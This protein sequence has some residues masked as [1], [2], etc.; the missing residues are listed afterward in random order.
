M[1]KRSLQAAGLGAALIIAGALL[2]GVRPQRVSATADAVGL[3]STA[4]HNLQESRDTA[5]PALLDRAERL[6]RKSLRLQHARNFEAFLGMASLSNA[7]HRFTDSVKWAKKAI[8]VN[9]YNASSY[10]LLGDALFELGHYRQADRAYQK[11][12]DVRPDL[13]S[14]V[15]ASY[16]FQ[17]HGDTAAAIGALRLA[18]EAAGSDRIQAAW[19]RHQLGDVYFGM[20]DLHGAARQ[21]RIGIALAPGYVPPHVGLAEVAIGRGRLDRAIPV[22]EDATRRLPTLEYL[23]TLG[24]LYSADGR[25]DEAWSAY[26]RARNKIESYYEHGVEP[27]VDFVLFYAEH[28]IELER[29]LRRAHAIYA[30]RPTGSA[31]DAV[32]W[33]LH[34]LGRDAEA[35]PYIR[36]AVRTPLVDASV[37]LHAGVI[38]QELG[39]DGYAGR[40]LR[41]ASKQALQ[42]SPI[43]KV[44]LGALR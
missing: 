2:P 22:L 36:E 30:D 39:R 4:L 28:G 37:H 25:K 8:A 33:T 38:A 23:I 5:R 20:G 27:D 13:A 32:A 7:R 34:V 40:Q 24:D 31:A 18:L 29:T 26:A 41:A 3:A 6:L 17:F 42:L 11:M 35:W 14:Y 10:G 43:Q 9:P 19:I 16:A 1:R 12:S 15:R 21:N 44:V